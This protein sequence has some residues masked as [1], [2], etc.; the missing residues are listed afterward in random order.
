M[1]NPVVVSDDTFKVQIE[2]HRGVALVDVWAAW[3]GPCLALAPAVDELARTYAGRVKVAKLDLDAQPAT[4][5]RFGVRSIPTLLVFRDG[6][7]VDRL[8]GLRPAAAIAEV[9]DRHLLRVA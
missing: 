3:C 9:L 2:Q 5:Q 6:A 7:L 8:V 1:P 4:A